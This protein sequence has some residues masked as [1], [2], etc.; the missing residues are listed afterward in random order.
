MKGVL[1]STCRSATTSAERAETSHHQLPPPTPIFRS[2]YHPFNAR[3]EGNRP[4]EYG[5]QSVSTIEQYCCLCLRSIVSIIVSIVVISL[6]A[7]FVQG[8]PLN[9]CQSK[10]RFSSSRPPCL[11]LSLLFVLYRYPVP[12]GR[13]LSSPFLS[14]ENTTRRIVS[15]FI[16]FRPHLKQPTKLYAYPFLPFQL[17]KILSSTTFSV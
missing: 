7:F 3:T 13:F 5:L 12:R 10:A 6:F 9:Y 8:T 1:Y 2:S 17:K 15:C 4:D 16:S 11:L 14:S